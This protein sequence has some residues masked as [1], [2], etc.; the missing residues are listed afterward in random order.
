MGEFYTGKSCHPFRRGWG[1]RIFLPPRPTAHASPFSEHCCLFCTRGTSSVYCISSLEHC[2]TK[3]GY[4][5]NWWKKS[6]RCFE[7]EVQIGFVRNRVESNK[8]KKIFVQKSSTSPKYPKKGGTKWNA[9][10]KY[11]RH[12]SED[13]FRMIEPRWARRD[14]RGAATDRPHRLGTESLLLLRLNIWC[15]RVTHNWEMWHKRAKRR[16]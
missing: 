9:P 13:H 14:G 15:I 12:R 1:W 5:T 4:E 11:R 7:I 16:W 6:L 2:L 10:P 8:Y 3:M